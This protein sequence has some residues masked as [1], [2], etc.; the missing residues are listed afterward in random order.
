MTK[1]ADS[2]FSSSYFLKSIRCRSHL[3]SI[4][5]RDLSSIKIF[6]INFGMNV[7][8][9]C[10]LTT[11][12]AFWRSTL[13][14]VSDHFI[15]VQPLWK[16]FGTFPKNIA[17]RYSLPRT[18]TNLVTI[19]PSTGRSSCKVTSS[20]VVVHSGHV[21]WKVC[22]S[23][24]HLSTNALMSVGSSLQPW[25]YEMHA[26]IPQ[27]ASNHEFRWLGS[28]TNYVWTSQKHD[29]PSIYIDKKLI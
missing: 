12:I 3:M 22:I 9:Y 6:S 7:R 23:D 24:L 15:Y 2:Q 25:A 1:T 13:K 26:R 18:T 29:Y 28:L 17:Q 8:A 4:K 14:L 19:G 21:R 10:S 11:S 20:S 16:L 27:L 5:F